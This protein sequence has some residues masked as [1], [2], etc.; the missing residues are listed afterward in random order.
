MNKEFIEFKKK[1]DLSS[2]ITDAFKFVR[3]EG[4][5]FFLTILKTAIIPI[6]ISAIAMIYYMVS[7]SS[8]DFNDSA[9]T[10]STIL[11]VLV[12]MIA[13][14]A[15]Y[16]FIN[17]AAM[18]YIKSYIDNKGIVN[19]DDISKNTKEKFWSFTGFGILSGLILS[20]SFMLC[21]LPAFYTWTVLSLG[22]SILVFENES[23]GATVGKCFS[24]VKGHFWET[25]GVII[26]V[27]ILVGVLGYIFQIPAL[28]YQIIKT[29]IGITDN[30]PAKIASLFNDPIYIILTTIAVIGRFAF[31]S[32]TIVANVFIYFD[33]NEQKN[34]TGT[35]EKIENLGS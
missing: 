27:G 2:I 20:A 21:F 28:I 1:R 13:Y 25:F 30:D 17:L 23:A 29:T 19:K 6:I 12:M 10:M 22:A 31:Y 35:I 8:F 18:Y 9:N 34:S 4:K 3:Q 16:I 15:A 24:F 26:V 14:L 32:I 33:I 7:V 5:Q 11:S